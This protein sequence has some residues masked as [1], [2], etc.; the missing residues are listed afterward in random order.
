[1]PGDDQ[2]TVRVDIAN[3]HAVARGDDPVDEL[4]VELRAAR[5]VLAVR[6]SQQGSQGPPVVPA[7][8]SSPRLAKLTEPQL[9]AHIERL[10][11][12]IWT[13]KEGWESELSFAAEDGGEE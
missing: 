5:E 2:P 8:V 11:N 7:E 10:Q 9:R 12:D 13:A 6:D 1:M 3:T 4:E